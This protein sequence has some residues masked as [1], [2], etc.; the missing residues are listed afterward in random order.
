MFGDAS[1]GAHARDLAQFTE[2]ARTVPRPK[3][4]MANSGDNYFGEQLVNYIEVHFTAPCHKILPLGYPGHGLCQ[5]LPAFM[6]FPF[7]IL[8]VVLLAWWEQRSKAKAAAE[9]NMGGKKAN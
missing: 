9:A 1:R 2:G 3:S 7:I 4:R 8:P 5:T 6:I